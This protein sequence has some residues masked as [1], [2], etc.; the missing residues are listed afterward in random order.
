MQLLD[1]SFDG[2]RPDYFA[3]HRA[4]ERPAFVSPEPPLDPAMTS[5]FRPAAWWTGVDSRLAWILAL[6]EN[7]DGYG[8]GRVEH[9]AVRRAWTFLRRVMPPEGATPDIGP[10]KD[11]QLQFEWHRLSAD[12]EI[13]MLPTGE[14]AVAFDDLRQPEKSWDR[15]VT[16]TDF[17]RVLDA[18]R[19]ISGRA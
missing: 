19:E 6:P 3:L 15:V 14:F 4:F 16:A 11:G 9:E 7:W 12:L 13:R 17:P 2:A 18:I 1:A 10:T 8:A 5:P